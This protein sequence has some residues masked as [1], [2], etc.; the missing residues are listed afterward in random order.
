M[1]VDPLTTTASL[2]PHAFYTP[3][4]IGDITRVGYQEVLAA[5]RR[6]DL[7]AKF[8]PPANRTQIVMGKWALEWFEK[9]LTGTN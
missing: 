9:S 2:E 8:K 7:K 1:G 4:E 6:G 5:I 3:R